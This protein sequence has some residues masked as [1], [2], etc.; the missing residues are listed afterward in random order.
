MLIRSDPHDRPSK[1]GKWLKFYYATQADISP[2]TFIIFVNDPTQIHFTYRRFLE[3]QL[4]D[5]FGFTGTAIRL[6]FRGRDEGR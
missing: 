5:A 3:N 6:S 1:P 2:P 4:R